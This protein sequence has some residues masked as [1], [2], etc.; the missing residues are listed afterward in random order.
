[1]HSRLD[2]KYSDTL[3]QESFTKRMSLLE[4]AVLKGASAEKAAEVS[5]SAAGSPTDQPTIIII[6]GPQDALQ[7][8]DMFFFARKS[9]V[10]LHI[11]KRNIRGR[12]TPEDQTR[13][14]STCILIYTYMPART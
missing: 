9:S 5:A 11:L 12:Y 7:M 6:F 2:K 8:H 13:C 4:E 10:Q 3:R 1:M 14:H